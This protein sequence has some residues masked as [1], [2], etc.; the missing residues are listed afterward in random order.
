L[1]VAQA[2]VLVQKQQ[3]T[4]VEEALVATVIL[5]HKL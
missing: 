2:V 5:Q 3:V 4:E 1:A